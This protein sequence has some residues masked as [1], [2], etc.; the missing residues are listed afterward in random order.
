LI[1]AVQRRQFPGMNRCKRSYK[2]GDRI[3]YFLQLDKEGG[4]AIVLSRNILLCNATLAMGLVAEDRRNKDGQRDRACGPRLPYSVDSDVTRRRVCRHEAVLQSVVGELR[5]DRYSH[6]DVDLARFFTRLHLRSRESHYSR[7]HAMEAMRRRPA[8]TYIG[9]GQ[10]VRLAAQLTGWN[11][12]V[13]SESKKRSPA[14]HGARFAILH[15]EARPSSY[16]SPYRSR[17]HCEVR[18]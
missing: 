8:F 9:C 12:D 2:A 14:G 7:E 3:R 11:I 17:R 15:D 16:T 1:W 5:E 18:R 4:P 13:Y 6:V 10:N